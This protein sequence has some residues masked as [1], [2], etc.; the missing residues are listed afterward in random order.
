MTALPTRKM[1]AYRYADIEALASIRRHEFSAS[2]A[3][4]DNDRLA[5]FH[6]REQSA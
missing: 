5:R 1:E 3:N 4:V 6:A 2:A